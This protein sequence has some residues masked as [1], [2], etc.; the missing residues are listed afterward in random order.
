MDSHSNSDNEVLLPSRYLSPEQFIEEVKST[1]TEL[2]CKGESIDLIQ[3][4]VNRFK[5][6]QNQSFTHCLQ[7]IIA[8]LL[9]C[10]VDNPADTFGKW[11]N[12]IEIY[13]YSETEKGNLIK[14]L[15]VAIGNS[16][17]VKHFPN[18]TKALYDSD[19]VDDEVILQWNKTVENEEIKELMRPFVEWLAEDEDSD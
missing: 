17:F 18:I 11:S 15:E 13:A 3:I 4:E 1:V 6:D 10:V 14:E 9:G 16:Q 8:G 5:F 19:V 7:G 2:I 12:L